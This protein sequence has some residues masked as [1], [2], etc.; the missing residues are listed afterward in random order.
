[1]AEARICP[2]KGSN[3]EGLS[4]LGVHHRAG[5]LLCC[6]ASGASSRQESSWEALTYR[7]AAYSSQPARLF[8][9]LR[10]PSLFLFLVSLTRRYSLRDGSGRI[11]GGRRRGGILL[12]SIPFFSFILLKE[13]RTAWSV[14]TV[15]D[16]YVSTGGDE[17]WG[18]ETDGV[19]L[20]VAVRLAVDET[21]P[22]TRETT[23]RRTTCQLRKRR[24]VG[25]VAGPCCEY[26]G[27][28]PA[29][30]CARAS[31]APICAAYILP[32]HASVSVAP[33]P[34]PRRVGP[35]DA[36]PIIV[37]WA[38]D[39]AVLRVPRVVPTFSC[40]CEAAANCITVPLRGDESRVGLRIRSPTLGLRTLSAHLSS[41]R[42][43]LL[44]LPFVPPR[45]PSSRS[46]AQCWSGAPHVGER[47]PT[48]LVP[49]SLR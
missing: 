31:A 23:R 44:F 17:I 10:L 7:A 14:L 1:M 35:P 2:A 36:P 26:R 45:P 41:L 21:Y 8:L 22:S 46:A 20:D 32:A 24:A 6:R 18:R 19:T 27:E 47:T 49:D 29:L 48:A 25:G 16:V 40:R 3:N 11:P 5:S 13:I 4:T 9:S 42:S 37:P 39:A 30:G 12:A 34:D 33:A 28:R 38:V 15:G 43:L